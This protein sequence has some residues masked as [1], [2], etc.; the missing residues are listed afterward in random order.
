M[1]S[2]WSRSPLLQRLI[3]RCTMSRPEQDTHGRLRKAT[4]KS[5]TP[6]AST[7]RWRLSRHGLRSRSTPPGWEGA[8][9]QTTYALSLCGDLCRWVIVFVSA[10]YLLFCYNSVGLQCLYTKLLTASQYQ[11]ASRNL[12]DIADVC[13][14]SLAECVD[15][16]PAVER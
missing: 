5:D 13:A 15:C 4:P 1:T 10:S 12:I 6:H 9:T 3:H 14:S 11:A 8:A 16:R 7:R 2:Y